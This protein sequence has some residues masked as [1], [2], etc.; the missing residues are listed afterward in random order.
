MLT[1]F[2]YALHMLWLITGLN[3][4]RALD[5][6]GILESIMKKTGD[7]TT[8]WLYQVMANTRSYLRR[9]FHILFPTRCLSHS[10]SMSSIPESSDLES[11][12]LPFSKPFC[13][14]FCLCSTQM[15]STSI[16][17]PFVSYNS[18]PALIIC[19][20]K[21]GPLMKLTW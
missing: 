13:L 7:K 12:G 15:L 14:S 11:T 17:N 19:A 10:S 20:P 6:L 5:E 18:S 8:S 21:M 1:G 9:E 2:S 16:R 4:M 3:A